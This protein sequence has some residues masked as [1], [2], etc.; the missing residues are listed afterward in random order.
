M[1]DKNS[2]PTTGEHDSYD[3][4]Y[5]KYLFEIEDKHFWFRARNRVISAAVARVTARLKPGYRFLEVGCGT[6]NVLRALEKTCKNGVVVGMDL[7]GEGLRY[8]RGRV[9][10]PLVQGDIHANPF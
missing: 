1:Q 8:A 5:F 7:F 3:P 2:A 10:C 6:G 9:T 4:T